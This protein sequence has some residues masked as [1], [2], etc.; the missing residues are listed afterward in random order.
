MKELSKNQPGNDD[1]ERRGAATSASGTA[2]VCTKDT[3]AGGGS[4]AGTEG[5]GK[6]LGAPIEA[7]SG[8]LPRG[9]PRYIPPKSAAAVAALSSSSSLLRNSTAAVLPNNGK[10]N[11]E[12]GIPD[13]RSPGSVSNRVCGGGDGVEEAKLQITF[14][15]LGNVSSG[16]GSGSISPPR[17]CGV[18]TGGGG[19]G[20]EIVSGSSSN[21]FYAGSTTHADTLLFDRDPDDSR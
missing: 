14:G 21:S 3:A 20:E 13:L 17:V 8:K 6:A 2:G 10:G 19:G 4:R 12:G 1:N 5:A 9:T 15:N 7:I 18:T 16:N 11:E